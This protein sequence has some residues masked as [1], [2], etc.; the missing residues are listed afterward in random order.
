MRY[1][2]AR[3]N[4]SRALH[5]DLLTL[6]RAR[7][8]RAQRGDTA[9]DARCANQH[10][11]VAVGG[12]HR[13]CSGDCRTRRKCLVSPGND[14]SP[15]QRREH[16]R[17]PV[18]CRRLRRRAGVAQRR[19]GPAARVDRRPARARAL[20]LRRRRLADGSSGLRTVAWDGVPSGGRALSSALH[21][22]RYVESF[23]GGRTTVVGLPLHRSSQAAALVAYAPRPP[24]VPARR[25]TSSAPTSSVRRSTLWRSLGSRVWQRLRSSRAAFGASRSARARSSKGTS[26]LSCGR[27]SATR[28]GSSPRPSTACGFSWGGVRSAERGAQL[29]RDVARTAAGG[30]DRGRSKR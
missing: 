30:R 22:H 14:G 11:L 18:R 7:R 5:Q 1:A 8:E 6:G 21:D 25:A 24:A 23:D 2:S 4:G 19:S 9:G 15:G 28:S 17:R 3:V 27:V 12:L 29:P 16:R 26:R 10:A 13:D 20:R